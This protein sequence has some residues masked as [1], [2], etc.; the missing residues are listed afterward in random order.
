[1]LR[2]YEKGNA[3]RPGVLSGAGTPEHFGVQSRVDVITSTLGKALGG[4]AGGFRRGE[5]GWTGLPF[6]I[7]VTTIIL[8]CLWLFFLVFDREERLGRREYLKP[9]ACVSSI[10]KV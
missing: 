1:M 6:W 10:E 7:V 9:W 2:A 8:L 4:A 3:L 5:G